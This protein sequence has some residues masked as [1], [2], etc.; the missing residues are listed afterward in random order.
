MKSFRKLAG[1]GIV[2]LGLLCAGI[3]LTGCGTGKNQIFVPAPGVTPAHP[4]DTNSATQPPPSRSGNVFH[5]GDSVSISFS[6]TQTEMLDQ[7]VTVKDDGTITPPYIGSWVKPVPAAGRSLGDLQQEL[8]SL[9]TTY[10]PHITVTVQIPMRYYYVQGYVNKP[11]TIP[12][13]GETDIVQAIA[14]AGGFNEFANKKNVVLT[15]KDGRQQR[16]NV[17]KAIEDPSY[18][19]PVYPGDTIV[20]KKR[21]F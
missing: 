11:G 16:V 12:Y 13:V 15:H 14:A 18:H 19:V 2:S 17:I 21:I 20:V 5:V 10:Y 4:G 8:Q 1:L 3:L 9:Y 6:G 7:T